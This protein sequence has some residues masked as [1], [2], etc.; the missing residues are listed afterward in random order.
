MCKPKALK[1]G[2]EDIGSLLHSHP[3]GHGMREADVQ[4]GST[5]IGRRGNSEVSLRACGLFVVNGW[6]DEL[7]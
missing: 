1:C 6:K 3:R 4:A 5:E 2:A 7:R